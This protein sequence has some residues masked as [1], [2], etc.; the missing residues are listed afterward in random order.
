VEDLS[1][2]TSS[3]PAGRIQTCGVVL[4]AR[5]LIDLLLGQIPFPSTR[6]ADICNEHFPLPAKFLS[7]EAVPLCGT[8][9][10]PLSEEFFFIDARERS[11]NGASSPPVE[12]KTADDQPVLLCE[13]SLYW[14]RSS[15]PEFGI[16]IYAAL[17][18]F[19]PQS[20]F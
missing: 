5:F 9:K 2:W 12:L 20:F 17:V 4:V 3:E 15:P 10:S 19:L 7:W 13:T 6:S 8:V 16:E 11:Q 18:D 1:L 14:L